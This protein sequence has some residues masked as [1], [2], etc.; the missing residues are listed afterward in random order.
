ML[1]NIVRL[2]Q[3]TAAAIRGGVRDFFAWEIYHLALHVADTS[4]TVLSD[5]AG[6]RAPEIDALLKNNKRALEYAA[7]IADAARGLGGAAEDARSV[8]KA[9]SEIS[10]AAETLR[11]VV[12]ADWVGRGGA[13]PGK[14]LASRVAALGGLWLSAD[15][16]EPALAALMSTGFAR[17]A[18]VLGGIR[19]RTRIRA[20]VPSGGVADSL[21]RLAAT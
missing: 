1:P 2:C 15:A 20:R 10:Q 17:E 5:F 4:E 18:L 13:G 3:T 16:V 9:A 6:A 8:M 14:T 19:L 11:S 7:L 21:S 12:R